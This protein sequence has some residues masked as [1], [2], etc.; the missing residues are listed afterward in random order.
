[1]SASPKPSYE[2]KLSAYAEEDDVMPETQ[3]RLP[4]RHQAVGEKVILEQDHDRVEL[5]V[6][7]DR[8]DA[9]QED[10][11]L[12]CAPAPHPNCEMYTV[13]LFC[14]PEQV[15][16]GEDYEDHMIGVP[17]CLEHFRALS[18]YRKGCN[19]SEVDP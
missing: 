12:L 5:E 13:V 18:Q 17:V 1:M 10:D 14:D 7:S 3:A 6:V 11:C 19:V 8:L 15:N 2:F 9:H 4:T 16:L